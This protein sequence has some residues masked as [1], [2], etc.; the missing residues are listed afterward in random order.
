M[1]FYRLTKSV[2]ENSFA[3]IVAEDL[4]LETVQVSKLLTTG[5]FPFQIFLFFAV[6]SLKVSQREV[7]EENAFKMSKLS[8]SLCKTIGS[9]NPFILIKKN[10]RFLR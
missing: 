10:V 6:K 2:D 9:N 5:R 3:D 7:S 4:N 1:K 8:A